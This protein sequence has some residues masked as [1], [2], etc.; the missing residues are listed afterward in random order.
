MNPVIDV[1]SE[2][3]KRRIYVGRLFRVK[4]GFEFQYSPE[5]LENEKTFQLGEDMPLGSEI[6][7]FTRFPKSLSDRIPP[8]SSTNYNRYCEES[9]ISTSEN[10]EMILLGTIGHKGPSSFVFEL[11]DEL[12]RNKVVLEKLQSFRPQFALRDLASLFG[13]SHA[14]IQRVLRGDTSGAVY[15]LIEITLLHKQAFLFAVN[16]AKALTDEMRNDLLIWSTNYLQSDYS[17]SSP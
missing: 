5:W 10:D 6:L 14:S 8:R 17:K 16:N 2:S 13:V 15:S 11:S 1:Y 4:S 3:G 12:D 9:G 7:K